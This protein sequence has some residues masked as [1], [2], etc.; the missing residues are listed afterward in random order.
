LRERPTV[1]RECTAYALTGTNHCGLLVVKY[2]VLFLRDVGY[3]SWQV[4]VNVA[5]F[6]TTVDV[7]EHSFI[8]KDVRD[9][10]TAMAKKS[11]AG[12]QEAAKIYN[13][14]KNSRMLT[15]MRNLAS[16]WPG[17]HTNTLGLTS[18]DEPFLKMFEAYKDATNGIDPHDAVL[19]ALKEPREDNSVL[20]NYLTSAVAQ[21]WD[22]RDQVVKKNIQF[23]IIMLYALHELEIAVAAYKQNG[24]NGQSEEA[25]RYADVWWAFYAGSQEPGNG[26]GFSTYILAERRAKF[27]GT[28]TATIGNGGTSQVNDI[29]LKATNEIK[30]LMNSDNQAPAMENVMK[31][32]R[33]QLKVPLIQACIQYGYKTDPST[34]Y[35][36]GNSFTTSSGYNSEFA[37]KGELWSFCSGVLPFLHAVDPTAAAK[38][39]TEVNVMTFDGRTPSWTNIKSVFQ[40]E[41]LNKMGVKCTDVG[42][43]V[44]KNAQKT[45]ATTVGADFPVC[46]DGSLSS[47][48]ADSGQ[49]TGAWMNAVAASDLG[50]SPDVA[51]AGDG[52][53]PE[54]SDAA[55]AHVTASALPTL[56]AGV[57]TV[58]AALLKF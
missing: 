29:L 46:R 22:F 48:D 56:I 42:G 34:N 6:V 13:E 20:G 12:F 32:V 11:P 47:P 54:S 49:C 16:F 17:L 23:Q 27:F 8:D 15:S 31:C 30:R 36:A 45:S 41:H 53:K 40:A 51:A 43:F 5:G 33:A 39:L 19:A 2:C 57:I 25:K 37:R 18:D 26:Q 55:R 35:E 9:I 50:V 1:C 21:E 3:I 28:D 44:D 52:M 10:E 58:T 14:G 4:S 7:T 38:L 24:Q